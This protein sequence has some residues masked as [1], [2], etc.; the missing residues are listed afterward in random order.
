MAAKRFGK[1][2]LI[3]LVLVVVILVL[4]FLVLRNI[5]YGE[6]D[7]TSLAGKL[8]RD[9]TYPFQEAFY[10]ISNWVTSFI[11]PIFSVSELVEENRTLRM[12][13]QE[14]LTELNRLYEMEQ[15]NRRLR[16]L[17]N[18]A[19]SDQFV[20][21][22]AQVIGQN[23]TDW[24]ATILLNK[25]TRHGVKEGMAVLASGGLAGRI[26]SASYYTSE[27]I[28]LI[29]P[30]SA[31]G[32]YVQRS[33]ELVIVEGNIDATASMVFKALNRDIDII[34]GDRII[35]SGLGGM[36]PKGIL[37]GT[38]TNVQKTD[39][40]MSTIGYVEPAAGFRQLEEVLIVLEHDDAVEEQ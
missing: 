16:E 4:L 20:L 38:V 33:R 37:I 21:L 28:L 30:L 5:G 17:L 29:D 9:L 23:L 26:V 32:G 11:Q 35:T 34:E 6:G 27:V 25:G 2:L 3:S 12:E 13:N 24:D 10:N 36:Y 1:G 40:G 31:V 19:E 14:I 8:L 39:F 15:E 7:R 22:G 18:Y